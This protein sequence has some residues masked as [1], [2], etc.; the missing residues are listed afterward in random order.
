MDGRKGRLIKGT[1]LLNSRKG[2]KGCH[3]ERSPDRTRGRVR[4]GLLSRRT[5]FFRSASRKGER[6]DDSRL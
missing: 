3:P 5:D 2:T 1:L 6:V 4:V